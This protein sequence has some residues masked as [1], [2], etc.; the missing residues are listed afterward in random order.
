M[1]FDD[2]FIAWLDGVYLTNRL[3]AGAPTEPAYNATATTT[4][5]SSHGNA[6]SSPQPA[7]TYDFGPVG[8][9]LAPG[10]HILSII[11]VNQAL[12]SSDLIQV[13]DLSAA[14]GSGSSTVS[15]NFFSIVFSNSVV[16]SGSN[17]VAG[18]TRVT[19]NG[20]DAVFNSGSGTWS[21]T[22]ALTPDRK[23]T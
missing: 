20:D 10:T 17:T 13:A 23:S 14:S 18:S 12:T 3:V 4:H 2:G 16:L 11:G 7:E 1:D 15:G 19:I 6:S 22:N 9:R 21:K 5:E 8:A